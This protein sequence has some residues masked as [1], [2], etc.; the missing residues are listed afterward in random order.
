MLYFTNSFI[1]SPQS[2]P[3]QKLIVLQIY[4]HR[5]GNERFDNLLKCQFSQLSFRT[6]RQGKF[7]NIF[8]WN[9]KPAVCIFSIQKPFPGN[10]LTFCCHQFLM[11]S[12]DV[13]QLLTWTKI[14]KECLQAFCCVRKSVCECVFECVCEPFSDAEKEIMKND[15]ATSNNQ[16]VFS[17][18][19]YSL[20]QNC[21]L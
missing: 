17:R 19:T 11:D 6:R 20:H 14:E 15:F 4:V 3:I 8:L 1:L 18:P 10:S 12:I 5:D 16:K 13:T 21:T 2:L 9:W 7:S